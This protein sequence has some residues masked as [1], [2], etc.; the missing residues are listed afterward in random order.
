[1]ETAPLP[2]VPFFRGAGTSDFWFRSPYQ[3]AISL[4][5]SDHRRPRT[6]AVAD[7]FGALDGIRVFP[8][9]GRIARRSHCRKPKLIGTA[10]LE[11]ATNRRKSNEN[12]IGCGNQTM[13]VTYNTASKSVSGS[14]EGA[15][16]QSQAIKLSMISTANINNRLNVAS[17]RASALS[18]NGC[19]RK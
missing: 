16:K 9:C 15:L 14:D 17:N 6:R 1:M 18:M 13:I 7:P 3:L 8:D 10:R 11:S 19:T 12:W 4:L 5:L 2:A